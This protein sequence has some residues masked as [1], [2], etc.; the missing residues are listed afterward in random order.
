MRSDEELNSIDRVNDWLAVMRSFQVTYPEIADFC[1][2]KKLETFKT[3]AY[4]QRAPS[5]S[6][7]ERIH[8][9]AD[10]SQ[11]VHH[12]LG[13][14]HRLGHVS[15]FLMTPL[16]PLRD[17]TPSQVI[18]RDG[19][20]SRLDLILAAD[21]FIVDVRQ[22]RL[23][24]PA[25]LDRAKLEPRKAFDLEEKEGR[26][27]RESILTLDRV[28]TSKEIGQFIGGDDQRVNL[29]RSQQVPRVIRLEKMQL[30]QAA[31]AAQELAKCYRPERV[32][33][34]LLG[35]NN[36]DLYL[37]RSLAV[38]IGTQVNDRAAQRLVAKSLQKVVAEW[39]H[40]AQARH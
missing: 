19:A 8:L 5:P 3:W 1:G 24:L 21:H 25:D 11:Y 37:G 31:A 14:A 33:E 4:E 38:L 23:R 26:S 40:R 18:L 22:G 27:V 12:G 13:S 28:M 6:L 34:L 9:A 36:S 32:R 17:V 16:K 10:L 35:I 39:V 2:I 29:L 30:E 7:S 20:K 15:L